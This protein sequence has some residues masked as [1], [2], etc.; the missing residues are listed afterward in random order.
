MTKVKECPE[1]SLTNGE[2]R[3]VSSLSRA[4]RREGRSRFH[5]F[6]A[7]VHSVFAVGSLFAYIVIERGRN[8]LYLMA[9]FALI[10]VFSF[11][12]SKRLGRDGAAR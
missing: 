2:Y 6:S 12:M 9:L 11:W 10:A 3:D 8:Y 4:E 1:L 5:R 7:Y